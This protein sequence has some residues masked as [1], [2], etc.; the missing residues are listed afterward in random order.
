MNIKLYSNHKKL[1]VFLGAL[2]LSLKLKNRPFFI[3]SAVILLLP[4]TISLSRS[5]GLRDAWPPYGSSPLL[6]AMI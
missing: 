5:N 3:F 6:I 4:F 2:I 1:L